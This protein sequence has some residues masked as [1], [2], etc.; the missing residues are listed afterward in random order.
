MVKCPLFGKCGGCKLDFAASDYRDKKSSLLKNIPTT[1]D[2]IWHSIGTRRRA[3]FAFVDDTFGFFERGSKNIVSVQNC[4]LLSPKLNNILP[5]LARMPWSGGG[6]VLVTECENGIDI[7]VSASV[8]YFSREFAIAA[9]KLPAVRITWNDKTVKQTATPVIDFDGH[10]V[11]YSSGAFL[12]PSKTSEE[13]I[14]ELI[15]KYGGGIGKTVDLFCGLGA[16]ALP[17]G[18]DGYDISTQLRKRDL[19]KKPLSPRELEKYNV[20][21]LDPPRAGAGAQIKEISKL[22]PSANNSKTVIYVSCNPETFMRDAKVLES[23]GWKLTNLTP[24]DQFVGSDHW[25]LVGKFIQS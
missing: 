24:V 18:A 14:R 13:T 21:V 8:P 4:P 2:P 25:E 19:V 7:A 11:N 10:K 23:A 22:S 17:L 15:K 12:Q 6:S 1:D 3:D 20:I 9:E 16:F 5:L